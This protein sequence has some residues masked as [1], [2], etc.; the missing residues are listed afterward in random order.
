MTPA[1]SPENQKEGDQMAAGVQRFWRNS[2]MDYVEK[3]GPQDLQAEDATVALN[4]SS[5]KNSI[6]E[7]AKKIKASSKKSGGSK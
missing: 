4:F 1:K 7:L 6:E 5:A 2:Y 3:M